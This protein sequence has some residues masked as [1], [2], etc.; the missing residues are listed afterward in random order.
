MTRNQLKVVGSLGVGALALVLGSCGEDAL[1]GGNPILEKLAMECGIDINCEAGGVLEGN[2]SISGIAS[3]DAFFQSVI[4][5][6]SRA[7]MVASGIDAELAAIGGAFGVEGDVAAGLKAK[8]DA[9]LEG[10]ITLEAEP[11]R[12]AVDANVAVEASARC[13]GEVMPPKA[14]VACEGSCEVEASATV[15]CDAMADL[16]CTATAPSIMC[17]GECKGSCELSGSAAAD[18]SGTCNGTCMGTCSAMNAMGQCAGSCDGMCMGSCSVQ[19]EAE[20]KCEGMC[21][22]ECTV[23]NPSAG[24]EGGIRAE[25]EA[26]GDAMVMCEGRCD[27]SVEPPSAKVECQASAKAEASMQVEC[28]PPRVALHYEFKASASATAKAEMEAG[29][30]SLEARLPALLASM[31]KAE[32]VVDAGA[33]LGASASAAIKEATG[34]FKADG[35]L[36]LQFGALCAVREAGTVAKVI[37]DSGAQLTAS[38]KAAT[39]VTALLK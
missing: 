23:T 9:N 26:K 3:V 36:R 20:A 31:R 29:I 8:F 5:F 6:Q 2:A 33:D 4:N 21:T 7:D 19:L 27:G 35:N 28:S 38:A 37:T 12:C 10:G 1:P 15:K 13:E 30:R 34:A 25:C 11:A 18:C 39:S 17:M 14:M 24:C 16:K 32:F 22:G